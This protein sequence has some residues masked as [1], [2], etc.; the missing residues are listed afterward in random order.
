MTVQ[1]KLLL[2]IFAAAK[3]SGIIGVI[4]FLSAHRLLA[5]S[6]LGLDAVLLLIVAVVAYHSWK[7]VPDQHFEEIPWIPK[8]S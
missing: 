8:A 5:G 7:Q 1:T 4:A 2:I 6:M 3:L